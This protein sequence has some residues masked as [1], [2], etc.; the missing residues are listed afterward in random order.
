VICFGFPCVSYLDV[1]A[2]GYFSLHTQNIWNVIADCLLLLGS[3]R[4]YD[5]I[6][7]RWHIR[8]FGRCGGVYVLCNVRATTRRVFSEPLLSF[9]QFNRTVISQ[10]T[11]S[12]GGSGFAGANGSMMIEVVVC[13]FRYSADAALSLW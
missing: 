8:R 2:G 1:E 9:M 4:R 3:C 7:R 10:L 12:F 13:P 5:Y 11:Y 6:S